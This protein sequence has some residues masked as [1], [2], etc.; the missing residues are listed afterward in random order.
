MAR[1]GQLSWLRRL[2]SDEYGFSCESDI[3]YAAAQAPTPE[4]LSWLRGEFLGDNVWSGTLKLGLMFKA[5]TCGRIENYQWLRDE[6]QQADD[7]DL[8]EWHELT[9]LA[10][11]HGNHLPFIQ[12]AR[13]EG[14]PWGPCATTLCRLWSSLPHLQAWLHPT[15]DTLRWLHAQDDFPCACS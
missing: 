7:E 4:V 12:W 14:C 8:N 5:A 2:C 1:R 11:A 10:A 13:A 15:E 3:F 9:I 6:Q